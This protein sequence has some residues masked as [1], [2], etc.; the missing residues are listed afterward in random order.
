MTIRINLIIALFVAALVACESLDTDFE[1]FLRDGE[2]VYPGVPI[3]VFYYPGNQRVALAWQPSPDPSI[4]RYM[5]YWNNHRDS[6]AV[7]ASTHDPADTLAV[8]IPGL[9]E[10][11]YSFTVHAYDAKGN[12]SVPL[13]I[14]NA[15]A[16]GPLYEASLFNR[17]PDSEPYTLDGNNMPT[18]HFVPGDTIHI[19]TTIEY[20][21][22]AGERV[23]KPLEGEALSVTL[24]DYQ[25]GSLVR[26]RSS[27]IPERHAIDT[28]FVA[29]YDTFPP[30]LTPLNK[31]L[32]AEVQLP[33]DVNVYQSD[34]RVS[35]L[36]DGS[37]GPQGYPNIY[38]SD[39]NTAIP[40]HFTFDLGQVVEN[41]AQLEET[42]RDCCNNP[43]RFEV[44][45]I[46]DLTGAETTLPGN[47][48]GWK[49][50]A[51]AK[52]WTLL[53]D[54]TRSDDGKAPFKVDLLEGAP[55]VRYI[56]I[57]V[58]HVTTNDTYYSNMSELTFWR[59]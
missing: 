37:V 19:A 9:Q 45:G 50:E 56:R 29:R 12:R 35:K 48:P 30:I 26:Y 49:D 57:R 24:D 18:L 25:A 11:V 52:G 58:L 39:G 34:T 1:T 51:L 20:T 27:Y 6:L 28:F 23:E 33:N 8:I 16:Y 17:R 54:V 14:K 42:G 46:D 13:E 41:I 55:P 44:W 59:K 47:D 15:R 31:A 32:F 10:Y 36:W 38:H 4:T 43:D 21:N 7:E 5:I 2:I 22:L 40:H 53:Q 3:H